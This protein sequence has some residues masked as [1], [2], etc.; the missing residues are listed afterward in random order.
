MA[1]PV[2]IRRHVRAGRRVLLTVATDQASAAVTWATSLRDQGRI[3]GFA[4]GPVT[5]EDT[6]LAL[7]ADARTES[8]EKEPAH[9]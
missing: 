3:D 9:V 8:A 6:Y 2:A 4:L 5:L 1:A 7:T